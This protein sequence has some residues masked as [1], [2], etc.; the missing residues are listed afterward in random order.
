[1]VINSYPLR[2]IVDFGRTASSWKCRP[3]SYLVCLDILI[4]S[5]LHNILNMLSMSDAKWNAMENF[6]LA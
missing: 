5:L 3:L 6:K 2:E 1:M 4:V